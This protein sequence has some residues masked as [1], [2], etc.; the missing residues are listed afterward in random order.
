M[1]GLRHDTVMRLHTLS[2][3]QCAL[4]V[5]MCIAFVASPS[6]IVGEDVANLVPMMVASVPIGTVSTETILFKVLDTRATQSRAAHTHL[7][8]RG[9]TVAVAPST[10]ASSGTL[11]DHDASVLSTAPKTAPL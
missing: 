11:S 8:P 1:L 9:S 4:Q 10:N 6:A 7:P 5:S 3:M 2:L